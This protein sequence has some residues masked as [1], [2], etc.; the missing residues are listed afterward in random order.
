MCGQGARPRRITAARRRYG[1]Y[2]ADIV[3]DG[4]A[5]ADGLD[6]NE[7]PG[8][9]A[10]GELAESDEEDD[11]SATESEGDSAAEPKRRKKSQGLKRAVGRQ[12]GKRALKARGRSKKLAFGE[13]SG[14]GE[15]A[16][17]EASG[18]QQQT[19]ALR[20]CKDHMSITEQLAQAG[21]GLVVGLVGDMT[22]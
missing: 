15:G 20:K 19:A 18:S 9:S 2:A 12:K 17:G 13:G 3:S 8:P 22:L 21:L 14:D 4:E 16:A 5:D 11:E 6:G 10:Q 1:R 7:R